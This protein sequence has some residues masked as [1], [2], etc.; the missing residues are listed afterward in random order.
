LLDLPPA[1]QR[2]YLPGRAR[3]THAGSPRAILSN[4]LLAKIKK[5]A[6][7]RRAVYRN[8]DERPLD[9]IGRIRGARDDPAQGRPG[10][11]GA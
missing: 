9:C 11:E 1:S 8:G 10:I 5:T 6:S 2:H 4:D 3:L 7:W